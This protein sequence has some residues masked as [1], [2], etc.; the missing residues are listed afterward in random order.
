MLH[1]YWRKRRRKYAASLGA[2]PSLFAATPCA[3]G[4]LRT[5]ELKIIAVHGAPRRGS[6]SNSMFRRLRRRR[7][8]AADHLT[9]LSAGSVGVAKA[10]ADRPRSRSAA[11]K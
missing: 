5:P 10:P 9:P 7:E 6:S 1:G 2:V 11:F 8:H 4:G 3:T